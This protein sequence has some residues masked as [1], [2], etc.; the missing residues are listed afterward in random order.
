MAE[1]NYFYDTLSDSLIISNSKNDEKVIGSV[2][3]AGMVVDFTHSSRIANI[4]LKNISQILEDLGYDKEI[5]TN[6]TGALLKLRQLRD[7]YMIY[8]L[9]IYDNKEIR[10]PY[11]LNTREK[12]ILA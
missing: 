6:L 7:G 1:K 11:N 3:L 12:I 5:L 9:L 2:S 10:I 4:E 8:C